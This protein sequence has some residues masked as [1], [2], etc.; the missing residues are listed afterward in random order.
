MPFD[1]PLERTEVLP[2]TD[3]NLDFDLGGDLAND[4]GAPAPA[5]AAPA[6]TP[7]GMDFDLGSISLDLDTP[8]PAAEPVPPAEPVPVKDSGLD[9][10]D[11]ALSEPAASGLPEDEGDPLSRKLELADEFR[12]I[13]DV[14]GA[15]DLLE[16]V[17]AQASG[18]LKTKAQNMLDDLG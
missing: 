10:G 13:G 8:A 3:D 5:P 7:A 17:V 16:E 2:A 15:R 18:A 1:A 9:F 14:E 11:F 4:F 12:Q 6:P